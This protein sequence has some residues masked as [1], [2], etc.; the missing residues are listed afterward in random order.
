M[1]HLRLANDD[2]KVCVFHH[3]SFLD[4]AWLS[5]HSM[6]RV[7]T[8]DSSQS[9]LPVALV[10]ETL[11]TLALLFPSSDCET[12]KWISRMPLA[13][14]RVARFR[15]LKPDLRQI[16]KFQRDRLVMSK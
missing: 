13:D 6:S 1:D 16:E 4:V 11:H 12:R 5:P 14:S 7:Q 10:S 15:N 9:L 3:T 8:G 2:T